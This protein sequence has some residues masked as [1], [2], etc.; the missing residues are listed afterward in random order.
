MYFIHVCLFRFG[1][2]KLVTGIKWYHYFAIWAE[3]FT[4]DIASKPVPSYVSV[5]NISK[6]KNT[7][8]THVVFNFWGWM[9]YFYRDIN[10]KY[11]KQQQNDGNEKLWWQK[12]CKFV[13][14]NSLDCNATFRPTRQSNLI[15]Q[16]LGYIM[17]HFIRI[18]FST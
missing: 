2:R 1:S 13:Y 17:T 7:N 12:P 9:N 10:R 14:G 6:M 4:K 11:A 18:S 16:I 5:V 8:S 15:T 3:S